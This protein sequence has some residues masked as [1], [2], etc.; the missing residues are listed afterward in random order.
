MNEQILG[1][2]KVVNWLLAK[3]AFAL[4]SALHIRVENPDYPI[5]NHI[6]MELL[7]FLVCALFFLWLRPRLS[8]EN[9]GARSNVL[10]C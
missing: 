10:K 8:V 4:L 7:V 5:P 3:P 1:V 2:T 9:P 6:S